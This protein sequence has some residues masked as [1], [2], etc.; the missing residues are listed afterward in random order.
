MQ[1]PKALES[2]LRA[3]LQ[4]QLS[5]TAQALE[6]GASVG[7][8][9]DTH[10][11]GLKV[12]VPQ[13]TPSGILIDT[14]GQVSTLPIQAE[15]QLLGSS[16]AVNTL[17][18]GNSSGLVVLT[19]DDQTIPHA[20]VTPLFNLLRD[21]PRS[22]NSPVLIS[23]RET[24]GQVG[25]SNEPVAITPGIPIV[26]KAVGIDAPVGNAMQV[27]AMNVL[28]LGSV[29]LEAPP[30]PKEYPLLNAFKAA[31][32]LTNWGSGPNGKIPNQRNAFIGRKE[33]LD[34]LHAQFGTGNS[35][36]KKYTPK[37][38]APVVISACK[39]LGGVGKTQLALR[40]L[41]ETKDQYNLRVWFQAE[42]VDLLERDYYIQFAMA[43]GY[44]SKDPLFKDAFIHVDKVLSDNPGWIIV[45]DNVS[46]YEDI[47]KF[48]PTA[49]GGKVLITTRSQ[50]W[51]EEDVNIL[52][53]DI[54]DE[55]DSIALL[56]AILKRKEFDNREIEDMKILVGKDMLEGLPLAI[57]QAGACIFH[58]GISISEYIRCYKESQEEML[59][60]ER[61][62]SGTTHDPVLITWKMSINAIQEESKK[63]KKSVLS[64]APLLLL[65]CAYL[66]PE[67]ISRKIVSKWFEKTYPE[68]KSA[69]SELLGMLHKYSLI[70]RGEDVLSLHRLVQDSIRICHKDVEL[71][72]KINLNC[73]VI[74]QTWYKSLL[75]V[76][77]DLILDHDKTIIET[78]FWR[79][80][81]FF[82]LETIMK[83]CREIPVNEEM[84]IIFFELG[85]SAYDVSRKYAEK[86]FKA[87]E[88]ILAQ[89]QSHKDL[90]A[91][92]LLRLGMILYDGAKNAIEREDGRELCEKSLK[93]SE[94]I[95]SDGLIVEACLKIGL[96]YNGNNK[97]EEAKKYYK[98]ALD[99][100]SQQLQTFPL[101]NIELTEKICSAKGYQC[102]C[103]VQLLE[104]STAISDYQDVYDSLKRMEILKDPLSLKIASIDLARALNLGG[105]YQEAQDALKQEFQLDNADKVYGLVGVHAM[106]MGCESSVKK[107]LFLKEKV[108]LE[109]LV[110]DLDSIISNYKAFARKSETYDIF[111][112][113]VYKGQALFE[114]GD[115]SRALLALEEAKKIGEHSPRVDTQTL[116]HLGQCYYYIAVANFFQEDGY[117]NSLKPLSEFF[118]VT[119]R[120]LKNIE[121][122]FVKI[123]EVEFQADKLPYLFEKAYEQW[124]FLFG[125]D[126]PLSKTARGY[127][128]KVQEKKLRK[129]FGCS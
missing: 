97:V 89:H 106:L 127:F 38:D 51:P 101:L 9:E 17:N 122:G 124:S 36:R 22:S 55:T 1:D 112:P 128:E 52:P 111:Y 61:L 3:K 29:R 125:N 31:G 123:D 74:N 33:L 54:M 84:A 63:L 129:A 77:R 79:N 40:Y 35:E 70:N 45:Y 34:E 66:A 68:F 18:G 10:V 12:R 13:D 103:Y 65:P 21:Q 15:S 27:T 110:I 43:L 114:L 50:E 92:T 60:Y 24:D 32:K 48:L 72:A 67:G 76:M 102:G 113:L 4:P 83:H 126:H 85:K 95:K 2:V 64:Y 87:A 39:G 42:N 28:A 105:R 99:T 62:P 57:A 8:L 26:M 107:S 80:E 104:L 25:V 91:E 30:A 58:Q 47:E 75:E 19:G 78:G 116:L 69:C 81:L 100:L 121:R 49:E 53:I 117:N 44:E 6:S 109:K 37:A 56:K 16:G 94:E 118:M 119:E 82:H 23:V 14:L 108:D 71:L 46:T 41:V 120:I 11:A 59:S 20:P 7:G 115:L 88:E 86:F 98:K 96:A 73:S 5:V 90:Y 93:I